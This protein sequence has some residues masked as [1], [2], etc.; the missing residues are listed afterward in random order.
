[1]IRTASLFSG[2][3]GLDYGFHHQPDFFEIVFANDF[4]KEA[5]QT[6]RKNFNGAPYLKEG[7]IKSFLS[8]VPD[9]D[10]L[11][12]G[13]PCQSWSLAGLRNGFNDK[14]GLEV[15]SIG[16]ILKN[17]RPKFFILE[18][19]KGILS[20][21]N[22]E[23]IKIIV[24]HFSELG[25][26]VHYDLFALKDY[27]INQRRERVLFFGVRNDISLDPKLFMPS[28]TTLGLSLKDAIAPYKKWDFGKDN[29]NLHVSTTKKQHWFKILKEGENLCKISAEEI[30]RREKQLGLD[31][32]IKP[33]TL[34]GYRRLN[35]D[36]ISPTMMFGN[37]CL[38]IHFSEDRNLSVRECASIQ[39]FP[40]NFIFCGGISAQYKQVGNAV[41]PMFSVL[42][43]NRLIEA[44][45][46]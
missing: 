19:V 37:T 29:H 16:T 39:S 11:L 38:P 36:E 23:S 14:R 1:M 40:D 4:T 5:C 3:G 24:T 31:H 6:Y 44:L 43:A 25:Y 22:G 10:L 21:D 26:N 30:Y 15:Y 9:H 32:V 8:D 27:G 18:N 12:G 13:F 42:L 33:K 41:P 35:G 28:K 45:K 7:D 20:H 46:L 17:K 2:V 34:T